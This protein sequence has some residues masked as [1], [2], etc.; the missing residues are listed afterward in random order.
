V[1]PPA[2]PAVDV[3]IT[4]KT[5]AGT[6]ISDD[7]FK[8]EVTVP[9]PLFQVL[10]L[11]QFAPR[12]GV[13]NQTITLFGQNFNFLPVTVGFGGTNATIS[14]A[15]SATQIVVQVPPGMVAAGG[16]KV[17]NITVTTA[18][19]SAVSTDTFTVTGP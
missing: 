11:P 1:V 18:G 6:I 7:T 3:K 9:A 16:T 14:G 19:G 17:V 8:A 13:G 2:G 5:T 15:P 10:P 4:V 12:S